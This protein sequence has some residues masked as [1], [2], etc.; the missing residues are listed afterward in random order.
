MTEKQNPET[1]KIRVPCFF[2]DPLIGRVISITQLP[3]L[4]IFHDYIIIENGM[5]T[6]KGSITSLKNRISF[7][8]ENITKLLL[9]KREVSCWTKEGKLDFWV[10]LQRAGTDIEL[11]LV[12]IEGKIHVLIPIFRFYLMTPYFIIHRQQKEWNRFLSE[13]CKYSGLPL[14]EIN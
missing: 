11:S 8:L 6:Y 10:C 3:T 12:D 7:N 2:D 14:E 13:L 5:L 1:A 4:G 9:R